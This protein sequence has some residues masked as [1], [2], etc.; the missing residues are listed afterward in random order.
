MTRAALLVTILFGGVLAAYLVAQRPPEFSVERIGDNFAVV[1]DDNDGNTAVFIRND[2]VVLVDSKSLKAGQRLLEV[3]RSVT[4]KP[5][6][7]ILHTHHHYDHTGGNSFFPAHVEVIAHENAAARMPAMEEFSTPERKH[8]LPDRT[9]TDRLT[10]FTGADAID[11][12]YFGPAHTDNDTFVVF[13]SLGIMH[14]GDT[15]PGMNAVPRHGGSAEKYSETMTKAAALT[16][17]R[18]VIPGHGPVMT[19]QQFA[20]NV[21]ALRKRQ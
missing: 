19:W 8:G 6:T 4:T 21:A 17:V 15:A 7:H 5:V 11:L 1:K 13:R 2:G 3:L 20:D 10:V 9:F 12:H 18:T 14:A 16:G